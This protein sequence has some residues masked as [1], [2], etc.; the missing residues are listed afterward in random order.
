MTND[1]VDNALKSMIDFFGATNTAPVRADPA[2][3]N[4]DLNAERERM[5]GHGHWMALE[6]RGFEDIGKKNRWLGFVQ[7]LAWVFG[8]VT[9]DWLRECNQP[10]T[11]KRRWTLD[12]ARALVYT[13]KGKLEEYCGVGVTGTVLYDREPC[14]DLD[15]IVYPLSTARTPTPEWV[16]TQL[17]AAGLRCIV[18]VDAVQ[19]HWRSKGS[20]DTKRVEVWI[21]EQGKRVDVFFLT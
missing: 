12:E 4:N 10:K 1:D 8:Y 18:A 19:Q 13:L 11:N 2:R 9:I 20:Q 21:T 6:A 15:V 17:S 16:A 5:M 7:A 14:N 3:V